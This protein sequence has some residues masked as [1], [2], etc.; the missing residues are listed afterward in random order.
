MKSKNLIDSFKY[1]GQGLKT[2]FSNERNFRIHC[3]AVVIVVAL[4][5][6]CRLSFLE[7]VVVFLASGFVLVAELANTA[8]EK[9]VD[10]ITQEYSEEAKAVKDIAAGVVLI[11]AAIAVFVGIFVFAQ[12]L[13]RLIG[14]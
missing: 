3:L 10:M 5:I 9:M 8:I 2:V 13:L 1:A 11:A 14:E 4:C 7:C 6:I 12:P